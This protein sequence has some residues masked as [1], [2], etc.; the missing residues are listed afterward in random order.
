MA[1]QV[2]NAF[3]AFKISASVNEF[4]FV[5]LG[6][7]NTVAQAAV[8]SAAVVGVSQE[9]R[10]YTSGRTDWLNVKLQ[11]QGGT[12]KITAS[13]A[14]TAGA[15]IY[16]AATGKATATPNAGGAVAVAN[17][18]AS[19]DG[20]VIEAIWKVPQNGDVETI[21]YVAIAADGSAGYYDFATG[22]AAAPSWYQFQCFNG[23]TGAPR[24]LTTLVWTTGTAR[25][26]V[27]SLATGD[28]MMLA[29]RA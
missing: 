5:A 8:A 17:E 1:T 10:D 27:A 19:A 9:A 28:K 4:R 29:Y 13:G 12:F 15:D 18:A 25:A 26:T 3:K 22:L 6:A 23:S 20:D 21:A 16:V 11:H 14:I 2:D 24:T 7:A